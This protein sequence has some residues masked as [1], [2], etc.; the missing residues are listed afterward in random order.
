MSF[1]DRFITK[2]ET[3]PTPVK[4]PPT[5]AKPTPKVEKKAKVTPIKKTKKK[6]TAQPT[7]RKSKAETKILDAEN[8]LNNITK[9]IQKELKESKDMLEDL[10]TENI[11]MKTQLNRFL[12]NNKNLILAIWRRVSVKQ[13]WRRGRKPQG[14]KAD[15]LMPRFGEQVTR[16]QIQM[17]LRTLKEAGV[18]RQDK[19]GWYNFTRKGLKTAESLVIEE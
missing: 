5:K 15:N 4:A 19:D 2:D 10:K 11:S 17:D 12:Y 13:E 6:T 7:P 8:L 9:V 18:L 14:I 1:R 16:S 3:A